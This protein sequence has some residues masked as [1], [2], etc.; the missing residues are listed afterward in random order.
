M[1]GHRE[2]L[3]SAWHYGDVDALFN[4][5]SGDL[6]WVNRPGRCSIKLFFERMADREENHADGG[7]SDM[8][9][10]QQRTQL[11]KRLATRRAELVREIAQ[12][13]ADSRDRVGSANVDQ[14]IEGGDSALAEA[15]AGLDL[16]EAQRDLAELRDIEAAS[17]R[18][19]DGTYGTCIDCGDAIAPARLSAF[20]IAKRCTDCQASYERHHQGPRGPRL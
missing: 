9:N 15:M 16:A 11:A 17:V 2:N 1:S 18:L 7:T 6:I 4:H 3:L 20:P 12:K 10:E 8:L 5:R 13:M 14:I 19:A